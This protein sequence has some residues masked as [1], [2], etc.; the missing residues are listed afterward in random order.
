MAVQEN[1]WSEPDWKYLNLQ[2]TC[3]AMGNFVIQWYLIEDGRSICHL[4]A[5]CGIGALA[6]TRTQS[7][8]LGS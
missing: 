1:G 6:C 2:E 3:H 7:L 5:M 4:R 8:S